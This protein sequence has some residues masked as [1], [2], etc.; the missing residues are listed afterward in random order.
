[1]SGPITHVLP[2]GAPRLDRFLTEA[3]PGI[4]RSRWDTWVRAGNV[5]VNGEVLMLLDPG[6]IFESDFELAVETPGTVLPE[7]DPD[8][9]EIFHSRSLE[10]SAVVSQTEG[11]RTAVAVMRWGR[12]YVCVELE[13]VL[14]FSALAQRVSVPCCPPHVVGIMNLR[15]NA[16]TLIDLRRVL[17]FTPAPT[18]DAAKVVVAEFG[19]FPVGIVVD[20]IL[21]VIDLAAGEIVRAS[22]SAKP[23]AGDFIRGVAPYGDHTMTVLNLKEIL[24][25]EGLTVNEEV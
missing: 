4:A 24:A 16:L 10:L 1:M 15:G 8:E 7:A 9:R 21:E 12:E 11:T 25:W 17:E 6:L 5:K 19:G 18:S 14:E 2:E 20:E 13:S 3:H 22:A 23:Y